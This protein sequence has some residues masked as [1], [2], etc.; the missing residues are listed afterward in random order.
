MYLKF[1]VD[2]TEI[3]EAVFDAAMQSD[4]P[5]DNL[6]EVITEIVKEVS[7]ADF[8]VDLVK[9]IVSDGMEEEEVKEL[10]VY[11]GD[12]Y[13]LNDVPILAL[14]KLMEEVDSNRDLFSK[15]AL[16]VADRILERLSK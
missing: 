3:A 7:D 10:Y 13:T 5:F 6:T 16:Q 8:T 1:N 14:K 4:K 12:S 2:A 15:N 11:L 9:N